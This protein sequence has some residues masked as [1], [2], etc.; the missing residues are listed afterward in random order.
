[1]RAKRT[2]DKH[3]TARRFRLSASKCGPRLPGKLL[4]PPGGFFSADVER[5][6][7][8]ASRVTSGASRLAIGGEAATFKFEK[9]AVVEGGG[10]A[11]A[12][13]RR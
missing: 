7:R 3:Q 11:A 9:G 12:L 5:R 2:K 10:E 13:G 8:H 6:M 1:M 4:P